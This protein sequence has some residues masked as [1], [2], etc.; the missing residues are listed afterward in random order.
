EVANTGGLT[1]TGAVNATLPFQ[2]QGGSPF[3][4]S[5][6]QTG[7]VLVSFAPTNAASFSNFVTFISNAGDST[8]VVTGTWP[9]I[10]AAAFSGSPSD[11]AAPL[12]V[13]F[14]DTSSGTITNRMWNFGDGQSTNTLGTTVAHT[15][16]TPGTNT[17][18]LTVLG[19]LGA[20]VLTRTNYITVTDQLRIT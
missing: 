15:Y 17:V 1:L 12:V 18:S 7:L 2:I 5:H 4:L 11:G 9:A 20:S 3:S 13:S 14:S 8:N 6:G 19:P 10:P 16:A